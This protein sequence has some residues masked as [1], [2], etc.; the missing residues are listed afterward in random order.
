MEVYEEQLTFRVR[1]HSLEGQLQFVTVPPRLNSSDLDATT[2]I[3]H[4]AKREQLR[5]R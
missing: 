4:V 2:C 3:L 5:H 1:P